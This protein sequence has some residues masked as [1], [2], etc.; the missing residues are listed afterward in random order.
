MEGGGRD[1]ERELAQVDTGV[2]GCEGGTHS[3][4]HMQTPEQDR[5]KCSGRQGKVYR[6]DSV[7]DEDVLERYED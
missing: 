1:E 6:I 4:A 3:L 7:S 5:C 2:K